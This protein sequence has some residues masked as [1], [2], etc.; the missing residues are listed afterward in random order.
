MS[1]P[2]SPAR[3]PTPGLTPLSLSPSLTPLSWHGDCWDL[4]GSTPSPHPHSEGILRMG[5][6]DRRVLDICSPCLPCASSLLFLHP[7]SI[8]SL[9]ILARSRLDTSVPRTLG[10]SLASLVLKVSPRRFRSLEQDLAKAH[11]PTVAHCCFV[12]KVLLGHSHAHSF[13]YWLWLLSP[14]SGRVW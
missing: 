5:D 1:L 12:N 8:P 2:A 9:R 3:C 13:S 6:R 4:Q 14:Y 7:L 11:G 10:R